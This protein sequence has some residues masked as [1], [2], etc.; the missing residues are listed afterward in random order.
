MAHRVGRW[1]AGG[2]PAA[3]GSGNLIF[4]RMAE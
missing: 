4:L 3:A 2:A 1:P